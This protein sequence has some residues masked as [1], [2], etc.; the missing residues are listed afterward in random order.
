MGQIIGETGIGKMG[1]G[2]A[3]TNQND[4]VF[5]QNTPNLNSSMFGGHVQAFGP[6][7]Y[8]F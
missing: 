8:I 6:Q 3:G 7:L 4:K 5:L 1:V 2:E